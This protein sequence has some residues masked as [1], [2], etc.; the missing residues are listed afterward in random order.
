M[1]TK[2]RKWYWASI[3]TN[4]YS[5]SVESTSSKDFQDLKKWFDNDDYEPDVISTFAGNIIRSSFK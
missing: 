3:F 5:S 1:Q 4:R 2:I